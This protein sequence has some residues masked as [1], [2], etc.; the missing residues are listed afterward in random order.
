MFGFTIW[1]SHDLGV[2]TCTVGETYTLRLSPDEDQGW[3]KHVGFFI[4]D[5]VKKLKAF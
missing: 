1:D 5:V 4:D 2:T 3:V